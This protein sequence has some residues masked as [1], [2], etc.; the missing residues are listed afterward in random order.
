MDATVTD[1]NDDVVSIR[2]EVYRQPRDLD[3]NI[4]PVVFSNEAIED[5]LVTMYAEGTFM[6]R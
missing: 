2:W 1:P 4:V 6:L 5:S 3:P